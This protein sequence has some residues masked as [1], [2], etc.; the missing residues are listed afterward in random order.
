M[1]CDF[2]FRLSFLLKVY[3]LTLKLSLFTMTSLVEEVDKKQSEL[4]AEDMKLQCVT[5]DCLCV[6]DP[7]FGRGA[8]QMV[9]HPAHA[10][11]SPCHSHGAT[12]WWGGD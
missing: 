9:S 3:H 11:C 2:I 8:R 12:G 4:E 5:P 7:G 6:G 1:L 10:T